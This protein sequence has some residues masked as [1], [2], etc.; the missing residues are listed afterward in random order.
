MPRRIFAPGAVI[1]LPSAVV[2]LPNARLALGFCAGAGAAAVLVE[3][4][5]L[6]TGFESDLP[7]PIRKRSTSAAT[8]MLP[9]Y[10]TICMLFSTA[11]DVISS[12]GPHVSG[13]DIL[14]P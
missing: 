8:S 6:E 13:C 1:G 11:S 7:Q 10:R 3:P 5:S 4:G 2:I 9:G 12:T 14:L